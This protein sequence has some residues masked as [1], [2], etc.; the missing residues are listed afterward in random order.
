MHGPGAALRRLPAARQVPRPGGLEVRAAQA[1]ERFEDSNRFVRGRVVAALAAGEG[2]PGG[3]AA[4]AWS[5]RCRA[6][7]QRA[8]PAD[9][10][11]LRA[12]LTA[13]VALDRQSIARRDFPTNRRGYDPAA[14]DAH[15][16][17]V[18]DE[19]A[20]LERRADAAVPLSA[21]AGSR[22]R[23]S[24]RPRSAGARD[25]RRGRARVQGSLAHAA[26]AADRL[27]R[28]SSAGRGHHRA[29][30]RAARRRAAPPRG[31]RRHA[32]A[33]RRAG[34]AAEAPEA[35][36]VPEPEPE[37]ASEPT[38][39]AGADPA[40]DV[41]AARIVALDMALSGTPREQT[42]RYLAGHYQLGDRD[43]LLDEVYA[44]AGA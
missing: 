23:P 12:R 29:D 25:P 35:Q 37:A 14:V 21:Q 33:G 13:S 8:D 24:S 5:A 15:L 26:E 3:I 11:G 44:A 10:G 17:A 39:T 7:A 42:E 43:A 41:E 16:Q 19:V 1:V 18:A 28:A 31:A 20:G 6:C 22:S 34:P 9:G 32:G 40:G 38:A 30:G 2:L 4:T 27:R 36:P